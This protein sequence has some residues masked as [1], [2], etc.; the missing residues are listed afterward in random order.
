MKRKPESDFIL[1]NHKKLHID[2]YD[3]GVDKPVILFIPGM[4]C[5]A[6]LYETFLELL[7]VRG[8]NIIGIDPPGLGRSEGRRGSFTFGE[9]MAGISE[10]VSYAAARFN[11]RIGVFG[12]SLGGTYALYA[13]LGDERIRSALCHGAMDI[14]QDLHIPTRFPAI[15]RF[16]MKHFSGIARL[17]PEVP[18]PLR[19]L[20]NWNDVVD[21]SL[22][23]QNIRKDALMVWQYS[24]GSWLSFPDHHPARE[25]RDLTTPLIIV[26]GSRDRLFTPAHCAKL[27]KKISRYGASLE[28]LSGGHFLP[29]EYIDEILPV[30]VKWFEKTLNE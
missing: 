8:F 30:T 1:S 9:V 11:A 28:V 2:V 5:Y 6:G 15:F 29:L 25:L 21:S 22:I 24:L 23:L 13:S 7:S 16:S 20:V 4:G 19:I 18:V 27:A 17:I 26:T 12:T 3:S 10:A 14:S